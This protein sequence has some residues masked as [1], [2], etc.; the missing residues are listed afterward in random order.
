[1]KSL[2]QRAEWQFFAILPRVD[3]PLAGAWYALL[4]IRGLL[5]A[6]FALAMGGMIGAV[7]RQEALT[8]PLVILGVAFILLQVLPPLHQAVSMNLGSKVAAWLNDQLTASCVEPPGIGHLEDPT[9][10]N[11]LVVAREFDRGMTGP[12]MFMNVDFIAGSLVGM[13]S[14]SPRRC[15]SSASPGGHRRCW[16]GPGSAR[17]GCCAR[18]GSGA[19]ATPTRCRQAQRHADYAYKLAVDPPAAKELRLFG[20]ED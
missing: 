10:T 6:L 8:A 2:R 3:G 4:L 20:L 14:A 1:M 9:L 17:T 11:D 7:Q 13:I 19:T 5:P 12:P 18:A 15:C 16:R